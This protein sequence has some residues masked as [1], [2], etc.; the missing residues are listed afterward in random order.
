MACSDWVICVIATLRST[1]DVLPP[2][3]DFGSGR[4]VDDGGGDRLEYPSVANK[5]RRSHVQEGLFAKVIRIAYGCLRN[6]ADVVCRWSVNTNELTLIDA[7]HR[8]L[9]EDGVGINSSGEG[10]GGVCET[11]HPEGERWEQS[12]RTRSKRPF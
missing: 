6:I 1:D 7:I 4:Y 2:G 11:L 3:T 8:Q 9:L 10:E 5:T 12:Q